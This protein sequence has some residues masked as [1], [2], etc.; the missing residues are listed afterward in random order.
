MP[1]LHVG[2]IGLVA[3]GLALLV[4]R[5][6]LASLLA[7]EPATPSAPSVPAARVN[8][9][10]LAL[11]D[12]LLHAMTADRVYRSGE[13]SLPGLA[14]RLGVSEAKLRR[15]INEGLGFRNFND[16]LHHI[17]EAS[18]RLSS[19]DLPI[20]TIALEAGYGSMGPFNRAFKQRRGVTPS[21]FRA[22]ARLQ[23][24]RTP[25]QDTN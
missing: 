5:T 21:E 12:R 18:A 13:L 20:L 15:L 4:A 17:E 2:G 14:G 23:A 24:S 9:A 7:P 25:A 10:D 8:A 22:T 6:P 3:L 16:F 11:K 19:E 1:A